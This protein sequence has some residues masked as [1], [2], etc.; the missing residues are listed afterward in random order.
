MISTASHQGNLL[1]RTGILQVNFP[2][3]KQLKS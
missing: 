2:D 3:E 1:F